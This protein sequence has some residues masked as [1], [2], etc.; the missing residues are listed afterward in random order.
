[1]RKIIILSAIAAAVLG[2]ATLAEARNSRVSCTSTPA[3]QWLSTSELSAKFAAQGYTVQKIELKRGCGEADLVDS[4]GVR[5]EVR[6]DPTT[7]AIT[8]RHAEVSHQ[9]RGYRDD[10]QHRNHRDDRQH[11]NHRDD[12]R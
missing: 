4:N 8:A 10:R 11:R 6:F 2:G 12:R 9:S 1:M 7:G 3:S 5:T